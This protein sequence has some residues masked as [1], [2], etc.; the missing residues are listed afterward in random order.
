MGNSSGSVN[1][2]IDYQA[3]NGMWMVLGQYGSGATA[4]VEWKANLANA[5]PDHRLW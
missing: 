5:N 2:Y 3:S 4:T 1:E